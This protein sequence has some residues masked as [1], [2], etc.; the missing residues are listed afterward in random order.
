MIP[1][2]SFDPLWVGLPIKFNPRIG[3]P[4]HKGSR[5]LVAL[6]T[7]IHRASPSNGG[8]DKSDLCEVLTRADLI[9][10]PVGCSGGLSFRRVHFELSEGVG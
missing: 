10:H 1:Y 6:F 3:C 4:T 5:V 7:P 9:R 2:I 8:Y